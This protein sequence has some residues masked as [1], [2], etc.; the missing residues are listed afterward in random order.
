MGK[1]PSRGAGLAIQLD[2]CCFLTAF[3][4]G[5]RQPSQ[6]YVIS[7]DYFSPPFVT[8]SGKFRYLCSLTPSAVS[9]VDLR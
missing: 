1:E 6:F 4:F 9:V 2:P 5:L 8:T 3:P 7:K